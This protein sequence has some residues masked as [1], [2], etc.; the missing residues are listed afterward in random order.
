MGRAGGEPDEIELA[1]IEVGVELDGSGRVPAAICLHMISFCAAVNGS[2][3]SAFLLSAWLTLR[4]TNGNI[5]RVGIFLGFV[6]LTT[7]TVHTHRVYVRGAGRN[8]IDRH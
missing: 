5:C 8:R 2:P 6:C 7:R 3:S 1:A 4:K